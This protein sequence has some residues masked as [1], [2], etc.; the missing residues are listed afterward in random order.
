M[1]KETDTKKGLEFNGFSAPRWE[2]V[3]EMGVTSNPGRRVRRDS[4]EGGDISAFRGK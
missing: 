4:V 1:N 3:C 2:T